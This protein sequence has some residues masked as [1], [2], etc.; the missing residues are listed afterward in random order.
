[1]SPFHF[2][3][4]EAFIEKGIHELLR[5]HT[6]EHLVLKIVKVLVSPW[7]YPLN[8]VFSAQSRVLRQIHKELF[9]LNPL[10]CEEVV[11]ENW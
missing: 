1:M 11:G 9:F 10:A 2:W 6:Q 8:G 7:N 5:A 4:F 3:S